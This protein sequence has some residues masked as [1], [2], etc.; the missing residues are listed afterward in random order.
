NYAFQDCVFTNFVVP[1]SV[2]EIGDY[3]F[4]SCKPLR[5]FTLGTGVESIGNSAFSACYKLVEVYNLSSLVIESDSYENGEIGKYALGI[6]SSLETAS[7]VVTDGDYLLFVDGE[8]ADEAVYLLEYKGAEANLILPN[9][10]HGK[11]YAIHAYAFEGSQTLTSITVS[12]G[13]R[14]IGEGAFSDCTNLE[15]VIIQDTVTSIGVAAFWGCSA[16]ERVSM[17]NGV[18][19]IGRNAFCDCGNLTSVILSGFLE[20]IGDYAFM[21]CNALQ[22]IVIPDSV[23]SIGQ[24]ALR[25]VGKVYYMGR[26]LEDWKQ[27]DGYGMSGVALNSS[28]LYLY[29]PNEKPS[30]EGNYWDFANDGITPVEW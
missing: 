11:N 21:R 5:M 15:S 23:T 17:G 20:S 3:A 10:L 6:Y 28:K 22:S 19:S 12:L 9:S 14:V 30:T 4:Y 18:K 1:N 25:E 7:K 8:G 24:F 29:A 13:A 2:T 26:T 16:L 27:I